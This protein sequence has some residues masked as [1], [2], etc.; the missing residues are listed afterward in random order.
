M[1]S[2]NQREFFN[3]E[4][5]NICEKIVAGTKNQEGNDIGISSSSEILLEYKN[6]KLFNKE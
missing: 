2:P 4:F 1:G 3:D 6:K 5:F